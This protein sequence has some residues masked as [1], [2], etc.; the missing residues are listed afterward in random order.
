M[1]DS[2]GIGVVEKVVVDFV[3]PPSMKVLILGDI[4]LSSVDEG[5]PVPCLFTFTTI[6]LKPGMMAVGPSQRKYGILFRVAEKSVGV[7]LSELP[8]EVAAALCCG[9]A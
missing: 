1:S 7:C 5:G 8:S 2:T 6:C 3:F 4:V 9:L